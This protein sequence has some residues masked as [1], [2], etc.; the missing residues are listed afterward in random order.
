MGAGVIRVDDNGE[1]RFLVWSSVVDAPLSF[2]C[3]EAQFIEYWVEREQRRAREEAERMIARAREPG[4]DLSDVVVANRAGPKEVAL[5]EDEILEFFV[6]R[7]EDPTAKTLAAY[8]KTK[9]KR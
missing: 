2:A 1:E 8:R 5:T 4:R 6:R 3:T 7:K 9:G